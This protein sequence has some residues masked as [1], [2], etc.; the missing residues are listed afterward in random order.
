MTAGTAP[1]AYRIDPARSTVRFVAKAMFF[2]VRGTFTVRDGT[3]VV[4]DDVTCSTV[5]GTVDAA[6]VDTAYSSP[7]ATTC[8]PRSTSTARA[9]RTSCSSAAR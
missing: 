2:A 3:I 6:S 8:G 1:A 7:R 9:T 5:T 4:A